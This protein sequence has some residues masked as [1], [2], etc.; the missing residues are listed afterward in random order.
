MKWVYALAMGGTA[1]GTGLNA[2]EGYAEA[3]AAEVRVACIGPQWLQLCSSPGVH[4]CGGVCVRGAQVASTTSLPFVTAKNKFEALSAHD[5]LGTHVRVWACS[6]A[7]A[8]LR[9]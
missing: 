4:D 6:G 2:I 9:A 7:W 5:A 1:V 8:H 3:F